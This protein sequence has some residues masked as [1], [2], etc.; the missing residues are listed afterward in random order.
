MLAFDGFKDQ[1]SSVAE[2]SERSCSTEEQRSLVAE[3]QGRSYII[4]DYLRSEQELCGQTPFVQATSGTS[5]APSS[6]VQEVVASWDKEPGAVASTFVEGV[7]SGTT[8]DAPELRGSVAVCLLDPSAYPEERLRELCREDRAARLEVTQMYASAEPFVDSEHS[9]A[10]LPPVAPRQRLSADTASHPHSAPEPRVQRA[11]DSTTV[12]LVDPE[13]IQVVN[14]HFVRW[15][16]PTDDRQLA[17]PADAPPV[18]VAA[19]LKCDTARLSLYSGTDFTDDAR[20]QLQCQG[21]PSARGRVNRRRCGPLLTAPHLSLELQHTAAKLM[22]FETAAA[23]ASRHATAHG[24][25]SSSSAPVPTPSCRANASHRSDVLR[26]RVVFCVKDFGIVDHVPGSVFSHLLAYFEDERRPRPS[27]TDM[28]HLSIDEESRV[29]AGRDSEPQYR[30]N[31]GLLPLKLTVDQDVVDFFTNFLQLCT[32]HPYVEEDHDPAAALMAVAVSS[33][34][35][36]DQETSATSP[37]PSMATAPN[38]SAAAACGV[39]SAASGGFVFQ[40]VSVSPV[41]LSVDYR[42]KRLDVGALRRGDLWELMNLLPLLEGLEVAFRRVTVTNVRG[43]NQVFAMVVS[44]WSTDLNR[45]Q[46]IRS[47]TGVTPIRSFA[48]IGSGFAEMVLEPMKQYR[49]GGG[50]HRVSRAILRGLISFMRHVTVESIDLTERIFVGT[51][52]ALEYATSCISD[53]GSAGMPVVTA[54]TAPRGS[55]ATHADVLEEGSDAVMAW[56]PVER[57]SS[58]FIQPRGAAEGMDQACTS[59]SRGMRY[60]GEAMFVRPMLEFQRGVRTEKVLRSMVAGIPMCVLRPAI[61]ATFAATT[62]LRG[63]R[64]SV[65][66]THRREIVRKYKGPE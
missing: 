44:H 33:A 7:A 47:L 32:S 22:C 48:N 23:A 4:E 12:W 52:S 19:T 20:T 56:T 40:R 18:E 17:P 21:L 8:D 24:G 46:I 57:G 26:R 61:G 34:P 58:D 27:H 65:D 41:L 29:Q 50:T 66:P 37:A 36:V 55:G 64:N 35:G 13:K 25:S 53:Q 39:A 59:L 31:F 16:E 14:D 3:P 28:L 49:S 54:G 2:P 6:T 15:D 60:A 45:T 11:D 43:I 62:A 63:V 51:Q 10:A 1:R 9:S 42:A 38:A 30:V 5:Q